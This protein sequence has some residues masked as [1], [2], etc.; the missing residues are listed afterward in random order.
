MPLGAAR[1][2]LLAFSPTVEAAAEVIR[3]KV[4]VSAVGNAQVDTSIVKVGAG[5]AVFDASGDYLTTSVPLIPASDD[6]TI[7]YWYYQQ[8]LSATRAHFQQYA[9]GFDGRMGMFTYQTTGQLRFYVLGTDSVEIDSSSNIAA[10]TWYHIAVVRNSGTTTMYLDGVNVGSSTGTENIYQGANFQIGLT[11]GASSAFGNIDEFRVSSTARY[12]TGFTAPTTAHVNDNDTLLLLHMD[13]TDGSTFFEDDNGT[14]AKV[15]VSAVGNAQVDTA[16]SKFGGASALFDGTGDYL[17]SPDSDDWELGTTHTTWTIEWWQYLTALPNAY[18]GILGHQLEEITPGGGISKGW[19][20]YISNANKLTFAGSTTSFASGAT[21]LSTNQWQHC[22]IV[23]DGSTLKYYVDGVLDYTN[24]GYTNKDD[25]PGVNL[26][27]GY[28]YNVAGGYNGALYFPGRIDDLRISHVARYT[29]A[30]TPPTAPHVNDSETVLLMHMDG[31]DGSTDFFD[32]NGS[33]ASVGVSAIGNA[34]VD[35]AQSKFGGASAVFD[36]SGDYLYADNSLFAYG[37]NPFTWECWW[38][39]TGSTSTYYTLIATE[40]IQ[41]A[42]YHAN[43]NKMKFYYNSNPRVS[44]TTTFNT[45]TWYHVAVTYDGTDLRMFINGTLE[46]T[47]TIALNGTQTPLWIG[48]DSRS[49]GQPVNGNIDE[50]R[51]SN[52]ARYTA[53]FTPSTTPFVNDDNTLLLLHMD[54]TDGSTTFTDDNG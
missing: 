3:A 8:T 30:F 36:G 28:A 46:D 11:G 37:S 48:K 4:G 17:H 42:L 40:A 32:D 6:F 18:K 20:A 53:N 45:N 35:T 5:S 25:A 15:G 10:D 14:R 54:G 34:Q 19:G 44:S 49:P 26:A 2:T 1:I 27:I 29:A 33:R 50:V 9:A 43:D 7:E 41:S 16:Q 31:T 13:G 23:R 38:Y 52:A 21:T 51:V 24:T 47:L 22:A 12:T 39:N